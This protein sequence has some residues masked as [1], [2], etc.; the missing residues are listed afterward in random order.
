MTTDSESFDDFSTEVAG[1]MAAINERIAQLSPPLLAI[2][3][4]SGD[5]VNPLPSSE[6]YLDS[7]LPEGYCSDA[8]IDRILHAGTQE[9]IRL[10]TNSAELSTMLLYYVMAESSL[11]DAPEEFARWC[12]G[13]RRREIAQ[14]F[15]DG[16]WSPGW[17]HVLDSLL[18]GDEPTHDDLA[19]VAAAQKVYTKV[20]AQGQ[21]K[22]ISLRF[23]LTDVLIGHNV[24][25]TP[26]IAKILQIL[27]DDFLRIE[28]LQIEHVAGAD[29]LSANQKAFM[30]RDAVRVITDFEQN[31]QD[32][33][34]QA[35]LSALFAP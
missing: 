15:I 24:V 27:S 17:K 32:P 26:Q 8:E 35:V 12:E 33:A 19:Q 16:R 6:D 18:P 3:V 10:A 4:A 13:C 31:P 5:A 9:F 7:L 14:L 28:Y 2:L 21:V 20:L 34:W 29:E 11:K 23:K 1:R 22:S 25:V 30:R